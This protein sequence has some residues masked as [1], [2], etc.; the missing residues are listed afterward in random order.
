MFTLYTLSMS[1]MWDS[2]APIQFALLH[3]GDRNPGFYTDH[4]LKKTTKFKID[5]PG[6]QLMFRLHLVLSSFLCTSRH[7][8]NEITEIHFTV[9]KLN[10]F[11]VVFKRKNLL[12]QLPVSNIK[13]VN[14]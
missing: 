9:C 14:N 7:P 2:Y 8:V 10:I 3:S 1:S 6:Y 11:L 5:L 4:C 13:K 12:N